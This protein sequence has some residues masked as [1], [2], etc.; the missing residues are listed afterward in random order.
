MKLEAIQ[1]LSSSYSKLLMHN[2]S[3]VDMWHQLQNT[4]MV[5]SKVRRLKQT[6]KLKSLEWSSSVQSLI[7][8][9]SV[10]GKVSQ[11]EFIEQLLEVL[12]P[13]YDHTVRTLKRELSQEPRDIFHI[14]QLENSLKEL[15]VNPQRS[16]HLKKMHLNLEGIEEKV[17]DVL[18]NILQNLILR[19]NTENV[20]SGT[21]QLHQNPKG[22]NR[23]VI[24][25]Q[26][27]LLHL[28]HQ[29]VKVKQPML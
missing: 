26:I 16:R 2:T 27:R 9:F 24:L 10:Y 3:L 7:N 11:R 22:K 21:S 28:L 6:T 1:F 18:Q 17:L 20:P 8:E 14:I 23:Q 29:P 15:E 12:P 13:T 4:I 25:N 19:E 5:K